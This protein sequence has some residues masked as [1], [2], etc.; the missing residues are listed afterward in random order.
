[1]GIKYIHCDGV[2]PKLSDSG[3]GSNAKYT[4]TSY[5]EWN[6]GSAKQMLFIFPLTVSL[7]T[8]TL[9]YYSDRV[10][11]LPRLIFYAVPDDFNVWDALTTNY[12]NKEVAS[13]SPGGDPEGTRSVSINVNFSKKRILMYKFSSNFKFAVSEVEFFMCG[14][15]SNYIITN[16]PHLY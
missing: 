8:I 12:P 7:T 16:M 13:V 1:M 9:H 2:T 5:Y 15:K 3:R 14:K 6:S 10:R 4:A 11:G